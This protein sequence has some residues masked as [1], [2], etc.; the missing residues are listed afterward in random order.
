MMLVLEVI[1][2]AE[3][4][5]AADSMSLKWWWCEPDHCIAEKCYTLILMA[6]IAYASLQYIWSLFLSFTVL[7]QDRNQKNL[8]VMFPKVNA[9][10]L[11]TM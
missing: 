6:L 2:G 7:I 1:N 9:L 3:K 5:L 11:W 10:S 8:F 4:F